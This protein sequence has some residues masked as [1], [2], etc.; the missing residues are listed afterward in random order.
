MHAAGGGGL[1]QVEQVGLVPGRRGIGNDQRAGHC[2]RR[3]TNADMRR[4]HYGK[5]RKGEPAR[6]IGHLE[7]EKRCEHQCRI[8]D[9]DPVA[10]AAIFRRQEQDKRQD[11][12]Q[13]PAVTIVGHGEGVGVR[14]ITGTS[15]HQHEQADEDHEK[16][17]G[18]ERQATHRREQGGDEDG[19]R[20]D[21]DA[22][23]EGKRRRP[24]QLKAELG[25]HK[26]QLTNRLVEV[27]VR[28]VAVLQMP[29]SQRL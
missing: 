13:T 11:A 9:V 27:D 29:G 19:G 12:K 22:D 1:H 8:G 26:I 25:Q 28:H 7:I 3:K 4:D 18:H 24:E 23:Q 10:V 2:P 14:Q 20:H 17:G 21:R 16:G 6:E 5:A 15:R